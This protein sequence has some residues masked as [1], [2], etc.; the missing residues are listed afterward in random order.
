V[1]GEERSIQYLGGKPSTD[2]IEDTIMVGRII[3][4]WI[5]NELD[6]RT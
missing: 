3:L 6:G 2:Y 5:L 4:K 1:W